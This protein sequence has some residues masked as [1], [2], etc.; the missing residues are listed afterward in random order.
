MEKNEHEVVAVF[1]LT[2]NGSSSVCS[3]VIMGNLTGSET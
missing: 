3:I 2:L 1:F